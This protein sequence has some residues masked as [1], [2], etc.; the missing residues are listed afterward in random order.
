[1]VTRG[2]VATLAILLSAWCGLG[3]QEPNPRVGVSYLVAGSWFQYLGRSDGGDRLWL[4]PHVDGVHEVFLARDEP[5]TRE[6]MSVKQLRELC[7]QRG[8]EVRSK[9]TKSEILKLLEENEAA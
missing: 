6:L 7:K 5:G 3:A 1:M 9:A 8:V 4:Y 2:V